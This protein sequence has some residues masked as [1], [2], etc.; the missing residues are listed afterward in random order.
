MS[1]SLG[2]A[3]VNQR[4]RLQESWAPPSPLIR[5]LRWAHVREAVTSVK[6]EDIYAFFKLPQ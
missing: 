3:Y 6:G 5:W 2:S 4:Y 1:K